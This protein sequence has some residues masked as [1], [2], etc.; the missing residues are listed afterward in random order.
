M[1]IAY[2]KSK[3]NDAQ[4]LLGDYF[5]IAINNYYLT[6]ET[7]YNKLL[8]S[9]YS[10]LIEKGNS[11]VIMGKTGYELFYDVMN[12]TSQTPMKIKKVNIKQ[13]T[14]ENWAGWILAYL[15]WSTARSFDNI[16]EILPFEKVIRMYSPYH[17]M[18][19]RNFV[20]DVNEKYFL[21]E[22]NISR[23]RKRNKFTQKE[24]AQKA[25]VSIR[26]IQMLEQRQNDINKTKAINLFN[27]SKVLNC[28][29]ED[30]LE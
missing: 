7:A 22:T 17:E 25:Q 30:L 27:I 6:P 13:N 15:Q 26:T 1:R 12:E 2:Q 29:M 11:Y 4:Y 18:D 3:L 21:K 16:G 8:I 20:E 10:Q 5:N 24:L 19:E 14:K 28:T 23:I 9:R